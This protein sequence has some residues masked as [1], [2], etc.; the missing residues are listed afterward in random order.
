MPKIRL[1][2]LPYWPP[3]PGGI[4]DSQSHFPLGGEAVVTEVF[5]VLYKTVTFRGIFEGRP[6][7][8]LYVASDQ[9]TAQKIYD[10][11]AV[12]RGKTVSE[13]GELEI[14]VDESAMRARGSF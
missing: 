7:S 11:I 8:Y 1:R 10:L 4:Y 2:E 6:H 12:N 5:P 3:E 9:R 13:L 14:E